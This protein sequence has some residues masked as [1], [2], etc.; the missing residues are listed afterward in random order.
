MD[1]FFTA[2]PHFDHPDI[3]W[4]C[5]R[6]WL[7]D[8]DRVNGKWT[9]PGLEKKRVDEMNDALVERWNAVVGRKDRVYI[10]GDWAYKR[11]SRWVNACNGQKVLIAGN[12]DAMPEVA[13][14]QFTEFHEFGVNKCLRKQFITM[15]H[16]PLRTWV[17]KNRGAW[18]LHGHTHGRMEFSCPGDS[19]SGGLMMDVGA[20]VWDYAPVSFEDLKQA[21]Q[22]KRDAMAKRGRM[23]KR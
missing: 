15:C 17:E 3:L 12:H 9:D 11:H 18:H 2:D 4:H 16:Y 13:Q 8:G 10:V 14:K 20:D 21:M 5:K 19:V 1:I 6:P 22:V 7:Q 23:F